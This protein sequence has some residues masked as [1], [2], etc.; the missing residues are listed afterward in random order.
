[1]QVRLRSSG[2]TTGAM[3]VRTISTM[4]CLVR[5]LTLTCHVVIGGSVSLTVEE[6]C[7]FVCSVWMGLYF[8]E[9]HC[10]GRLQ[11]RFLLRVDPGTTGS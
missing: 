11:E 9:L 6:C 1:M 10:F 2:K 8:R 3:T 7:V 4:H 5:R